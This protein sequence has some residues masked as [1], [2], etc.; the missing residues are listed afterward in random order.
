MVVYKS[1]PVKALEDFLKE[2]DP[3][4]LKGFQEYLKYYGEDPDY[5]VVRVK[6][7]SVL[8][9]CRENSYTFTAVMVCK[10]TAGIFVNV[11]V[12]GHLWIPVPI[13]GTVGWTVSIGYSKVLRKTDTIQENNQAPNSIEK[14][15]KI[16]DLIEKIEYKIKEYQEELDRLR[17][18]LQTHYL[19]ECDEMVEETG[20][21]YKN[22]SPKSGSNLEVH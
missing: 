3:G 17:D 22:M 4:K 2:Y 6:D 15:K 11:H 20:N 19:A 10:S 18:A 13:E 8:H 16:G 14:R 21:W 5:A 7:V 1:N 12:R 9:G